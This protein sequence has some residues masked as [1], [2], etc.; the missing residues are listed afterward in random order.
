MLFTF[1]FI[2]SSRNQLTFIPASLCKLP[3][4]EVLILNN[5]KLISLPE[6]IGQLEKLIELVKFTANLQK[7]NETIVL[8]FQDVSSNDIAQIPY[9]LG[10]LSSLRTLNLR[11]NMIAELPK[12][13]Y[14]RSVRQST[15]LLLINFSVR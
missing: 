5:N 8:L 4:L 11:R 3:N 9:Q 13:K 12:G 1:C 10:S 6:E 14:N 7:K 2:Q 15:H